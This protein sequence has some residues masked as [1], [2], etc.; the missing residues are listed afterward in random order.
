MGHDESDC[1]ACDM[2]VDWSAFRVE[3]DEKE[4]SGMSQYNTPRGGF[5]QGQAGL[6]VLGKGRGHIVYY[7]CN[8]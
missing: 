2:L 6:K 7:N 8:Q 3:G 4:G 1:G 5:H